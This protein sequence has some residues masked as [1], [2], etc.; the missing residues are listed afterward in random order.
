MIES[1]FNESSLNLALFFLGLSVL[2]SIFVLLWMFLLSKSDSY[3]AAMALFKF[4]LFVVVIALLYVSI[5][6]FI[7]DSFAQMI[8]NY[9]WI[10]IKSDMLH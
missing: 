2:F 7:S 3:K 8:E 10:N 9:L 4:T 5:G 1:I 6:Y